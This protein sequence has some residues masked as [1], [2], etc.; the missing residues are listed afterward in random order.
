[1]EA[2][3]TA[4]DQSES[5]GAARSLLGSPYVLLIL[6]L[7]AFWNVW[8]WIG[9]RFTASSDGAWALLPL[10]TIIGLASF[11]P[12]KEKSRIDS[13][14]LTSAAVFLLT[15][16]VSFTF[17]PPLVRSTLAII[18]ITFIVSYWRFGTNLPLRRLRIVIAKSADHRI[19]EFFPRLSDARACRRGS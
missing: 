14:S 5:T 11:I 16:A 18:S 2:A 19:A 17:T 6:Q 15:Y 13:L 12:P 3:F 10:L 4:A 7:T 9:G 1:M 8:Q